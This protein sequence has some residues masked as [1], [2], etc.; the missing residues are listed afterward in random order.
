MST[1][2]L[3]D[4]VEVFFDHGLYLPTRTIYMGEEDGT[5]YVMA[6]RVIKRLHVLDA[7]QDA[8]IAILMNNDGGD[9]YHGQAIYDAILTCK[10]HVTI[11]A[12]GHAM[13][14]GSIILQAADER[15]MAPNAHMMIHY[16]TWEPPKESHPKVLTSWAEEGEK[17]DK[18][19]VDL[20]LAKIK[21]KR[22]RYQRATLDKLLDFDTFLTAQ[23]TVDLGLADRLV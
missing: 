22:P 15:I 7:K 19:M 23:E 21:E 9:E 4:D 10:N 13:S 8:P 17:F 12:F 1:R 5:D 20:Y 6:E 3:I 18:W 14:M 11:T 16:G 2:R